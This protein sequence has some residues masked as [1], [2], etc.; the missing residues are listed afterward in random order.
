MNISTDR[1]IAFCRFTRNNSFPY[2][3]D[4]PIQLHIPF[5]T[6]QSYLEWQHI[7]LVGNGLRDVELVR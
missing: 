1:W 4:L 7:C 6:I 5:P 3:Y 2:Y